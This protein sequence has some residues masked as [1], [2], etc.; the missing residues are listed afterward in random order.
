MLDCLGRKTLGS[1]CQKSRGYWVGFT[2][3]EWLYGLQS[4]FQPFSWIILNCLYFFGY[5]FAWTALYLQNGKE[6]CIVDSGLLRY[7]ILCIEVGGAERTLLLKFIFKIC[8]N[9]NVK[10]AAF[11]LGVRHILEK[12]WMWQ[13]PT[14]AVLLCW[15]DTLYS[16]HLWCFSAN[17]FEGMDKFIPSI[18]YSHK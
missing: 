11:H 6:G 3:Y 8:L 14:G 16:M 1:F 18:F 5:F 15:A 2:Q 9:I 13:P 7:N 12:K 10:K 17:V 4:N